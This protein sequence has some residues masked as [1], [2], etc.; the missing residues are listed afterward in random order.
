[1]FKVDSDLVVCL[2][3]VLWDETIEFLTMHGVSREDAGLFANKVRWEI[4]GLLDY[5]K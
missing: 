1:M 2:A 4:E 5:A 3:G